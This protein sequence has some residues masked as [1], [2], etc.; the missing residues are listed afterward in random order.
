[1][2]MNKLVVFDCDGV[3]VDSEIISNRID[4]EGL[5]FGYPITAEESMALFTCTGKNSVTQTDDQLRD[6]S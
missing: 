3:L 4:A 5:I 2:T 6:K 1:M